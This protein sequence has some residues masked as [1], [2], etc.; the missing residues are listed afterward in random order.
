MVRFN[1][2]MVPMTRKVDTALA[3]DTPPANEP[4]PDGTDATAARLDQPDPERRRPPGQP[5]QPGRPKDWLVRPGQD[6]RPRPPRSDQPRSHSGD[7]GELKERMDALPDGNPSS[8][9]DPN[10]TPRP[11]APSLADYELPNGPWTDADWS[12]HV[13]D[14]RYKLVEARTSGADSKEQFGDPDNG[15]LWAP[16]RARLHHDI[17]AEAYT[18][19][20]D[21]PCERRAIIAGGLPGAGKTTVLRDQAGIDL[22]RFLMINPDVFK[23]AMAERGVIPEVKGLSPMEASPLVHEESSYL[24][25]ELADRA[26]GDG[27]NVIWDITMST[28]QSVTSRIEVLR[29][30]GYT[31]IGAVFI[32]IP[33]EVS[34]RR[35]DERH[36]NGEDRYRTGDGQGGRYVPDEMILAKADIK[37]GSVNRA[38]FE[39]VKHLFDWWLVYDNS[40]NG[41]PAEIVERYGR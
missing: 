8:P 38:A 21:V 31:D 7:P 14:I 28:V 3:S 30:N 13:P 34:V 12:D 15:G 9:R 41:Q 26:V 23:E 16:E 11:P 29:R 18:K 20:A 39:Q 22:Y 40:V 35:A 24:A 37:Y 6:D 25:Q 4:M 19:A 2:L 17:L 10:G 32:D 1:G 36:R 33:V 5:T 27:R